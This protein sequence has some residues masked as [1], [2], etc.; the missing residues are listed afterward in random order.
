MSKSLVMRNNKKLRAANKKLR[1]A[2][3]EMEEQLGFCG[4]EVDHAMSTLDEERAAKE[5]AQAELARVKA[6]AHEEIDRIKA[7]AY[8]E[9]AR[10]K[11]DAQAKVA[12]YKAEAQ[13]VLDQTKE[14]AKAE[15]VLS[16]TADLMLKKA[17]RH[18]SNYLLLKAVHKV[19]SQENHRL[20]GITDS[21]FAP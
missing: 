4:G 1:E 13:K 9:I 12:D 3:A 6:K 2:L 5:E 18:S 21:F 20:Y 19:V 17:K 7:K 11:A 16:A 8:E 15:R 14:Q 10:I